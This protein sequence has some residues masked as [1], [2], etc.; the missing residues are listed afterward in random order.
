MHGS[1]WRELETGRPGQGHG[2][3]TT[4]RET[5]GT[6]AAGPTPER[7]TAPA[8][9]PTGVAAAVSSR[10]GVLDEALGQRDCRSEA[11]AHLLHRRIRD[12][13]ESRTD[14]SS[15]PPVTAPN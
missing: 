7:V 6:K 15:A 12:R 4:R 1:R 14:R 8:P 11:H 3:G 13:R 10:P 9:D 2:S 5:T